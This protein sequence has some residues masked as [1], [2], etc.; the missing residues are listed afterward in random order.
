M[1]VLMINKYARVTGG[2][3]RQCMSLAASLRHDGHVVSFLATASAEN[4]EVD[5]AFVPTHVTHETRDTL[6]AR[7]RARVLR[8]AA[9]N[10]TAAAAM[11]RLLTEFRP[12]VV[13]AHLL[14]PQLSV[15]PIRVAR[16]HRLPIVQT[17]HDYEFLSG[18]PFDAT[19]RIHDRRASR[20]SYRLLNTAMYAIR[21]ALHV[22]AVTEW[23]AVSDFVA[24]AHASRGID[25]TVIPNFADVTPLAA[26]RRPEERAGVLFLGALSVEKGVLDVLQ[27]ARELPD[28]TFLM[29]GRGPLGDRVVAEAEA[30]GNLRYLGVLPASSVPEAMASAQIVVV[31]SQWEEPGSLTALEAMAVGTPLVVYRRGGLAEYVVASGA[32]LVIE[33]NWRSLGSACAQLLR[34]SDL[35]WSCANAGLDA[36]RTMFSRAAHVRAVVGVY[37]R[38]VSRVGLSDR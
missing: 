21:R 16:R 7:D 8:S 5:G 1:R 29:A 19:G 34:D 12:D 6:S 11:E 10:G 27:I 14:Y 25:S 24:D 3:D 31:P 2:A 15:S 20:R 26:P 22:P 38:A 13:H 4:I 18:D 35:W 36:S 32:G 9:W 37:E 17:L 33:G 28:V 30:L 23:I